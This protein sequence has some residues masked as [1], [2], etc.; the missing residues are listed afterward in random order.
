M[1]VGFFQK[2]QTVKMIM[3]CLTSIINVELFW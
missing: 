2:I 3:P 1:L